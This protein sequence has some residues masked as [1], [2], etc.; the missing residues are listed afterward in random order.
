MA[1]EWVCRKIQT[2]FQSNIDKCT[3]LQA[4]AANL[5]GWLKAEVGLAMRDSGK[6]RLPALAVQLKVKPSDHGIGHGKESADLL[7]GPARPEHGAIHAGQTPRIWLEL[8]HRTDWNWKGLEH[9]LTKWDGMPW[10]AHDEVLA[11]IVVNQSP[12]R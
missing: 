4:F 9:D 1:S 11:G 10:T 6:R 2:W 12:W 8:K 3:K 5:E 7:I